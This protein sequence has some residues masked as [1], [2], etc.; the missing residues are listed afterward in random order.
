MSQRAVE[1][2]S[3]A[4]SDAIDYHSIEF[5]MTLA[6]AI[7]VLEIVKICL[8]QDVAGVL[9]KDDETEA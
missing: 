2:L 9:F 5:N 7:G 8:Q 3:K 1:S 6:E 4:I